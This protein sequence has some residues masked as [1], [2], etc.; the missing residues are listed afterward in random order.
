MV[1]NA[2]Y[3]KNCATGG[4]TTGVAEAVMKDN[5]V[6]LGTLLN[7][8]EFIFNST[9]NME[10][11]TFNGLKHVQLNIRDIYKMIKLFLQNG[12]RHCWCLG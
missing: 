7:N 5:G 8:G 4:L 9:D 10:F 2:K 11:G 3:T 6:I 12:K 1:K